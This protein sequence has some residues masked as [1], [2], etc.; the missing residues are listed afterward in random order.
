MPLLGLMLGALLL[1]QAAPVP[2]QTATQSTGQAITGQILD[3]HGNPL[4]GAVVSAWRLQYLRP[5][6]RRLDFAGKATSA[7]NGDYRI[8]GLRPGT[9]FVDAKAS[10]TIAPTFFPATATATS[11]APVIVT[12]NAGANASIRLLATPLARV[13]GQIVNA[14][15]EPS[16]DFYV[17]LAPV[18]DD[19]AQ[20]S[21]LNLT[22]DVDAGGKFSVSNVPPGSYNVE[23]VSKARVE[24]IA[25]SGRPAV[26]ID[27]K[28]E[29][30]AKRV[31]VDGADIDDVFIRTQPPTILSGKVVLDGEPIGAKIAARL[32]LRTTQN[33]GPGGMSS[34]MN[35]SFA[36]P[37]EDGTFVLPAI[38][39]GRL[40][41]ADG[42]PP[43][44][45]LKRVLVRGADVTDEGFDVASTP[46]ADILVELTSKP[47]VIS[48]RI[49]D[50]RGAPTGGTGVIVYSTDPSRWRLVLTRVIVSARAKADGTFSFA[51]LPAGS[52]YIVS[53]PQLVDGEWAEPANLERLRATAQT[54]KLGDGE[55]KDLTLIVRK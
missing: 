24:A 17:I 6:E 41:R 10:E 9:Y 15:G 47:A 38:P 43:G 29:S 32:T 5:G 49:V 46:I 35:A 48:G 1:Q 7:E 22:S 53:V 3:E 11:A 54:F 23:V 19:G 26:G 30:G 2:S 45:T 40:V 27:T 12:A 39:G 21:M 36:T 18:R 55:L 14:R 52:Y 34:V 33:A 13:S 25:G 20:V 37:N 8:P 51:G 50:D 42:L 28:E 44:A 4:Q 31:I 16:S